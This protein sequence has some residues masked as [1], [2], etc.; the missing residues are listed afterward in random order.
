MGAGGTAAVGEQETGMTS[1]CVLVNLVFFMQQVISQTV[2]QAEAQQV[3][4][5]CDVCQAIDCSSEV[6][7]WIIK[8]DRD[9]VVF[10]YRCHSPT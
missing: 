4:K 3:V 9:M 6:A 5:Q 8:C 1:V 10:R 2:T 7:A